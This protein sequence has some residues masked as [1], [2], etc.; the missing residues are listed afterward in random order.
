VTVQGCEI[1]HKP[2]GEIHSL[3]AEKVGEPYVAQHPS[4][5]SLAKAL[6]DIG[7]DLSALGLTLQES[8]DKHN[9]QKLYTIKPDDKSA[10]IAG[11]A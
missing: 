1:V 11:F 3:L 2:A 10:G 4:P 5:K 7:A 8:E 9:G 6:A